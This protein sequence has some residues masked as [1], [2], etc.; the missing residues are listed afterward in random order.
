MLVN[1]VKFPPIATGREDD[2][3]AW[4]EWSN[5]LYARFEGFLSRRLLKPLDGGGPYVGIVEHESHETFMAMH[6]SAERQTARA[7]V[8]D[9]FEG[10][11][12]PR[13]YEVVIASKPTSPL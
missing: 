5:E 12:E 9:L 3:E 6:T 10:R 11:P 2:F 13:F 8:D 1:I 7:R 4:F